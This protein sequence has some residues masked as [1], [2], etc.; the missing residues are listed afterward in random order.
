MYLVDYTV[1]F[2]SLAVVL[3]IGWLSGKK[4]NQSSA[5]FLM[6]G[7]S[8]NRLQ[9]GLSMA[10][11]DFGGSGLIGAIGYCY[12]CGMSGIWWN[13][14]AAP[15]FLIVGLLFSRRFNRM[16]GA[17]LPDYFGRRY[18]P[19][20]KYLTSL[21]HVCTNIASLSVLFTVSC[22]VLSTVTGLSIRVSLIISMLLVLFLTSGGLR[23]VVNTDATLFIIIV[24]SV[25]LT[26]AF[27]LRAGGGL[28]NISRALPEGFLRLDQL[29]AWTPL[30]WILLCTLSYATNQNYIQRMVSAKDEGTAVFGALFT[31][32]FYLIISVA[33]G[34]IGISATYLLPDISDTNAVFP[35]MMIRY[36]PHGLLGLG[37]ASVFAATISTGT[38]VLHATVTL[39]S[40]D[41]W[42]PTVGKA[43]DDRAELLVSRLAVIVTALFSLALSLFFNNIISV[44]YI[45]GLFYA[46]S[47]FMPMLFGMYTRFVTAKAALWSIVITVAASLLWEYAPQLRP[48]A[49]A[50]LPSN[51]FG[52]IVSAVVLLLGSWV[53]RR[54]HH[55]A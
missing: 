5:E 49:L 27:S 47:A 35:E 43:A 34:L 8:I 36:F 1:L 45:A 10:A 55:T 15:A 20:V 41:L 19:A 11:T 17:T 16:D 4:R 30:S 9:A 54:I 3:L 33:L 18:S 46:V 6:A 29:G 38:S 53:D 12:V 32:G 52:L 37:L 21:M 42:K 50:D 13:L 28:S 26:T 40:T 22:T 39:I 31:A 7:K 2:L 25:L 23:A 48:G 51:A 14:A 44:I 24:I